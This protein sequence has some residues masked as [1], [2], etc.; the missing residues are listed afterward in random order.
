MQIKKFVLTFVNLKWNVF[1]AFVIDLNEMIDMVKESIE[2]YCIMHRE[3]LSLH[4]K[5]DTS[6]LKKHEKPIEQRARMQ[7]VSR[8]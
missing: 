2:N 4:A 8:R 5:Y 6:I 3:R 1:D 7:M